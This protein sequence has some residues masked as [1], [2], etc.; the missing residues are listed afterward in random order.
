MVSECLFIYLKQLE[1]F[2]IS[3]YYAGKLERLDLRGNA[4]FCQSAHAPLFDE[5]QHR[6]RPIVILPPLPAADEPYDDD[7]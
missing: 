4:R 1:C 2:S 7:P 6:G 5:F 3:C